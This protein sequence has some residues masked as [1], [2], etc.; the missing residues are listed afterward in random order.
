MHC[1]SIEIKPEEKEEEKIPKENN[2]IKFGIL[3]MKKIQGK[4]DRFYLCTNYIP[5]FI[6]C[7]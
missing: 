4:I 6:H 7:H 2:W 5:S 3:L 1:L